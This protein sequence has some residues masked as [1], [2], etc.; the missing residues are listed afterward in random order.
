[1]RGVCS[2]AG[3]ANLKLSAIMNEVKNLV[4]YIF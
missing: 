2:S 4:M 3:E 1:M